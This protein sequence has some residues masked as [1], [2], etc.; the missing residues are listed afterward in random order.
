MLAH[1]HGFGRAA[2]A[3]SAQR[4]RLCSCISQHSLA[5][6]VRVQACTAGTASIN[7]STRCAVLCVVD[8][9]ACLPG[10]GVQE[11]ARQV[12]QQYSDAVLD[13]LMAGR[14]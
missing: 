3:G 10:G 5:G 12:R 2:I 4:G 6:R 7:A 14:R 8:A 1:P 11:Q 13:V 9:A